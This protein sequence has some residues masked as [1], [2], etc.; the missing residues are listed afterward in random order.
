[1]LGP[2]HRDTLWAMSS[3]AFTLR[4]RAK[5]AE[6]EDLYKKM[7][8]TQ[9]RLLG[10]VD[11]QTLDTMNDLGFLYQTMQ[12]TEEAERLH[13]EAL[14]IRTRTLGSEQRATL[15]SLYNVAW[16][17]LE[18]GKLDEAD[19]LFTQ[20]HEARRRV[21]G[22]DHPET[23][24]A[25]HM[26]ARVR[27][28]QKRLVE[29]ERLIREVLG[30][31]TRVLGADHPDTLFSLHLAGFIAYRLGRLDEARLA[32]EQ[33]LAGRRKALG[34]DH[35]DTLWS[36]AGLRRV[37]WA[38]GWHEEARRMDREILPQWRR[39]AQREDASVTAKIGYASALLDG[40][41]ASAS[42]AEEALRHALDA[43]RVTENSD[44]AAL[45]VLALAYRT[46]GKTA[47]AAE[48]QPHRPSHDNVRDA[49]PMITAY[50]LSERMTTRGGSFFDGVPEGADAYML[51]HIIHDWSEPQCLT[52]LGHCRRAMAPGGRVLI[53]EMVLPNDDTPHFGK[54]LDLMMLVGPG[55]RERTKRNTPRC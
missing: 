9:D 49:D 38:G 8:A 42:D 37:Y 11:A 3:L 6:A 43:A 17:S 45:H 16:A 20:C 40:G 47:E 30:A 50:G 7:L 35:V 46:L 23:L 27:L 4:A 14:E 10:R 13:R 36:A 34:A 19:A 39:A 52:I 1:M 54:I 53:I 31:R 28:D 29:A 41:R 51:S 21:L 5:Y 55:G 25:L 18:L 15:W 26:L 32:L 22:Q 2:E 24:W 48:T 33:V 44:A 12:R